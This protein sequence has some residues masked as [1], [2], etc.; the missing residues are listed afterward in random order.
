MTQKFT[1]AHWG[2]YEVQGPRTALHLSP[3][4]SD[5]NPSRIGAGWLDAMQNTQTRIL[6]PAIR[7]GWLQGRDRARGGDAEFVELPWDE[8][9]DITAQE[10][11]RVID[12][13][14][15][16]AVF[17]GS[18]G[19][20]SA[21]RFHHAQSQLRRFLN[22]VGGFVGARD[23]YS[24][25]GAEVIFPHITGMSN[26]QFQD[27]MTSWPLI[28]QH[29]ETLLAFGGISKRP[30]QIA[31]GGTSAHQTE[32]WLAAAVAKGCKLVNISP[33]RSDMAA[34]LDVD[35]IAPRPNTDTALILAL[36][37]EIFRTGRADRAFLT[38]YTNGAEAFETYV[39]GAQD[40][41][42]KTPDWAA[43]LCDIP[44]QVIRDLADRISRTKTMIAMA[45]GMQRADRGEITL[46]AGLSLA[47]LLGQIGQPGTGFGFG[48][49]SSETVGRPKRW[50]DWPSV[51]QGRNP[52]RDFIPVARIADMLETPRAPYR[53]NGETRAYPD[54]K[55]VWW[56]GGNPFHHHQDLARL[57]RVWRAPETVV[58]M[59]H[60]WTATARRA[61]IVLPTT[62]ALERNDLMV[63]RRDPALI[64]M[65]AVIPPIGE[66]RDDF[67]ILAGLAQRM[68]V[69][70]AF[71][72]G[73]NTE[74]W[75]RHLWAGC[76]ETAV[77]L[78]HPLPE[79]ET[80]KAAG[81]VEIPQAEALRVQFGEFIADP[82]AHPLA[83]VS[84]KIEIE[85][86]AIA[87]MDLADCPA[88]PRW[89]APVEGL[90]DASPDQLHLVS[91]QP[92]TRLHSQN[93]S[94]SVA[95]ASKIQGREAC[96]LHPDAAKLRGLQAGDIVRLESPRGA[97]LAGLILS[98][99]MRPDCVSLPTGAW[100]DLREIDGETLCVHGNP[101]ML[102]L[103]KGST[104]LSQGNIAHTTL[105][106]VTKWQKPLPEI[107]VHS[108]PKLS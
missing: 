94:G 20:A 60:S 27:Q 92:D 43:Q 87:Q 24:H 41:T 101:N 54:A 32:D 3:L 18:Y 48:Y 108:Q 7:K 61:D 59:D 12:I 64:Y 35:W 77:A 91:G 13:H 4:S 72:E 67:A 46:W 74:D 73:R 8:A 10:L 19:W 9:L 44:A 37:Y 40:G 29:C 65:S 88:F 26:R 80:F 81:I 14:G 57:D 21:G 105:V 84:G 95:R 51:P 6:R 98:E 30:S 56:S 50:I 82:I 1:A 38:R 2:A 96:W 71:T 25:A 83:T 69:A 16:G 62:S 76:Q 79:F 70:E 49:G 89:S 78:G 102:T 99:A 39:M 28:V 33:L 11:S 17:A 75:L 55:M 85:S 93:D 104:E 42:P 63:S 86:A 53:Y 58:V 90:G 68:G 22:T 52:V 100:L 97:C 36:A 47:C 5:P 45:W 106:R 103:D 66:A 31:S 34:H 23:T 107:R 15:N